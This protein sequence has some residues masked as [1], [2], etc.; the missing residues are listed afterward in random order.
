MRRARVNRRWSFAD[1]AEATGYKA[2]VLQA[3][4][5]GRGKASEKMIEAICR[6]LHLEKDDLM[7]GQVAEANGTSGTYGAKPNIDS[8]GAG[9]PRYIPLISMA[10]AGSMAA[11]AFD[12]GGYEYEGTLAFDVRDNKAFGVTILGDSMAP[13]FGPGDVAIVYPQSQP[14]SGDH[15]VARLNETIGDSV[16]F[17]IFT[18]KDA[19]ERV[20]L[21]SYNPAY[22]PLELTRREIT[23][24]YPVDS[25][26]KRLRRK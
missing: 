7:G 12:D 4:E 18:P 13:V 25:V 14:R 3:I 26:M 5:D 23:W 2:D 6:A 1:L 10:Q 9:V 19:G 15:V 8:H 11:N 20:I 21:S 17:K 16:L 22:P 24:I